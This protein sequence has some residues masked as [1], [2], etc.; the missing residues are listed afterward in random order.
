MLIGC[1]VCMALTFLAAPLLAIFAE[2]WPRIVGLA[3]W[4]AMALSFVPTLR[5]YRLSPLW[6][7]ALPPIALMYM[8]YTIESA[9]KHWRRRGGEWKGRVHIDAPGLP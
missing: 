1:T 2:G 7:F 3:V 4:L 9:W 5:F 6:G 8:I